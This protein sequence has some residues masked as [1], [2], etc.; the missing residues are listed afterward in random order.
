MDAAAK[1]KAHDLE[2]LLHGRRVECEAG[3]DATHRKRSV[4]VHARQA[5]LQ[6]LRWTIAH[7][8]TSATD[9]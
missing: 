2:R 7:R 5:D 6:R 4:C 8:P 9:S 1:V 3:A